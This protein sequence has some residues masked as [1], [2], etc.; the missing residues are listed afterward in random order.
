VAQAEQ[1]RFEWAGPGEI[2]DSNQVVIDPVTTEV[3]IAL[4]ARA[5]IAVVRAVHEADDER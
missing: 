2:R 4:M 5:L 3:A 1:L